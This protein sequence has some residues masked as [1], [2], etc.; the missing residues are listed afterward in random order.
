MHDRT[1][2]SADEERKE[3]GRFRGNH[4]PSY[5]SNSF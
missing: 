2:M 4:S 1:L 3:E 5:I